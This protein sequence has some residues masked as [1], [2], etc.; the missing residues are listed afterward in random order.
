MKKKIVTFLVFLMA[1]SL[2]AQDG[3]WTLQ[4]C[5]DYALDNNISIKQQELTTEL[6]K[7]DIV[8]AEGNFYPSLNA[9]IGHNYNGV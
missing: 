6:I 8:T 3:N 1:V 7:E 4:E 5:I 9:N 2:H